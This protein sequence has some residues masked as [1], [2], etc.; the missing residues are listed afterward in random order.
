[1]CANSEEG[2]DFTVRRIFDEDV[3]KFTSTIVPPL[4]VKNT[5]LYV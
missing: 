1:M 5:P 2:Y 4:F 3:T